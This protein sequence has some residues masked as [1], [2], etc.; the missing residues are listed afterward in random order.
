M[1][2][3]DETETVVDEDGSRDEAA[4][5]GKREFPSATEVS[6]QKFNTYAETGKDKVSLETKIQ[7]RVLEV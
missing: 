4:S 2:K 3:C 7:V 5:V 1:L 6:E